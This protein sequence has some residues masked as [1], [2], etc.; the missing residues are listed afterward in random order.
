VFG[1]PLLAGRRKEALD[2]IEEEES[3]S[4]L[5]VGL[6]GASTGAAAALA[7]AAQLPELISA[8]VSR[9]GRPDLAANALANVLAP[10]LLIVGALDTV[11]I[12]LNRRAMQKLSCPARLEIVPRA[13]HLFEEVGTLE[14][15]TDLATAW[16]TQYLDN[17]SVS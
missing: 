2:W 6:F 1:I 9:G 8:V 17:S 14:R 13:A 15:V 3:T 7:A 16:F 11:V 12:E 10:T 4:D 5:A